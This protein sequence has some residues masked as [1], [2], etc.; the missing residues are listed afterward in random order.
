[1][2]IT[3]GKTSNDPHRLRYGNG[4][5]RMID[6]FYV[7]GPEEMYH[8]FPE[9]PDAVRRSQEIADGVD[10]QLNLKA[11]HSPVFTPPAGK[12]PEDHLRELCV[13]GMHQ[14]YGDNPSP[15]V[16]DRLEQGSG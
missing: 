1:L 3:P 13:K 2:C 5:E 9:L 11:R 7:C 12:T 15:A 16:R 14:R 10:I 8:R 4:D 6:Q